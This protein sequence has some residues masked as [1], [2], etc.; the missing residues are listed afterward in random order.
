MAP[1][2]SKNINLPGA[3]N[4][5]LPFHQNLIGYPSIGAIPSTAGSTS[6]GAKNREVYV[7]RGYIKSDPNAYTADQ[8]KAPLRYLYFLY[9]PSTIST[10]Y[11]MQ[12]DAP[13]IALMLRKDNGQAQ[14]LTQLQ[15][16]LD[17]AL[18]FDRTYEVLE[19]DPEGAWRDVRAALAL[20]GVM[21]NVED[22]GGDIYQSDWNF[23]TGPMLPRAMYFHFG[24][25]RGG[26]M[27]YGM[28]TSLSIEYTHFSRDMIPMRVGMRVS[29]QLLPD[30]SEVP[31]W[32]PPSSREPSNYVNLPGEGS[33]FDFDSPDDWFFG[34]VTAEPTGNRPSNNSVSNTPSSGGL[35]PTPTPGPRPTPP[36]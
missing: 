12:T 32:Q 21:D 24:N 31:L 26:M 3:G 7:E 20:V 18:L 27:F 15:Q 17:F 5:N 4:W 1:S 16:S 6:I 25:Q 30:P 14:P 2:P 11:S 13:T 34:P 29:A 19:G 10:G 22:R 23:Q 8:T 9:N 36:R 33:F 28:I 35:V